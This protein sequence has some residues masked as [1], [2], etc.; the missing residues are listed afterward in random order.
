M[1]QGLWAEVDGVVEYAVEEVEV[2]D[3]VSLQTFEVKEHP[4]V[5]KNSSLKEEYEQWELDQFFNDPDDVIPFDISDWL[6][7]P[8]NMTTTQTQSWQHLRPKSKTDHSM[9]RSTSR[10]VRRS[11]LSYCDLSQSIRK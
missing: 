1:T 10:G 3:Y 4:S 8:L 11:N 2:E 5:K 6:Q 9:K 7:K